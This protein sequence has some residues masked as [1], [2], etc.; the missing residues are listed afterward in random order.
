MY[1]SN[2]RY[3][4]AKH[5]SYKAIHPKHSFGLKTDIPIEIGYFDEEGCQRFELFS[6][7]NI[8]D[9]FLAYLAG[10]YRRQDYL[11]DRLAQ[12]KQG[13]KPNY[14][15]ELIFSAI[16]AYDSLPEKDRHYI[17]DLNFLDIDTDF[18]STNFFV[19]DYTGSIH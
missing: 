15:F 10:A 2:I 17:E 8:L 13:S 11:K 1:Y 5:K 18:Y 6:G 19:K 3:D 9:E 7:I 16:N 14:A 12:S 4:E